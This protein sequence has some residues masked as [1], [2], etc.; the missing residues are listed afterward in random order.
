MET[1]KTDDV[2]KIPVPEKEHASCPAWPIRTVAWVTGVLVVLIVT[3]A[4]GVFVGMQKARF[5]YDWGRNYERY[6]MGGPRPGMMEGLRFPERFEGQG[7]RNGHGL[8]G[9]VLSVS[10]GTVIVKDRSDRE[11]TVSVSDRTVIRKGDAMV[12]VS[13]LSSGERVTVIGRP[14]SDGTVAADFIRVFDAPSVTAP[15]TN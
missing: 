8:A 15:A 12:G 1:P 9:T 4:F 10:D 11:N 6:F 3:F 7:Y 2:S 13:D 14:G 5:S